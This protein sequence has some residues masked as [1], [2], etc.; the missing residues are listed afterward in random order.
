MLEMIFLQGCFSTMKIPKK[1]IKEYVK[2]EKLA[3]KCQLIILF[4]ANEKVRKFV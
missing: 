4:S 2:S 1:V 3:N